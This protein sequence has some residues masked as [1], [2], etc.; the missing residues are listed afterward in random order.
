MSSPHSVLLL[1]PAIAAGAATI[2]D[3]ADP[4]TG[5]A[6]PLAMTVFGS[7]VSVVVTPESI[8]AGV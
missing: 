4:L 1:R 6:A 7:L 5:S 8:A 2:A 3:A